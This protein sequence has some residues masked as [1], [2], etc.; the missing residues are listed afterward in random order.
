LSPSSPG[1]F[2]FFGP[3]GSGAAVLLVLDDV[4]VVVARR[5][6]EVE[7]LVVARA[8][9][10]ELR[11]AVLEV[12]GGR[13]L[14]VVGRRV[15]DVVGGSR[16]AAVVVVEGRSVGVRVEVVVV[17]CDA[18]GVGHAEGGGASRA[19]NFPGS[20]RRTSPPKSMPRLYAISTSCRASV[21]QL[22]PLAR[23]PG[24]D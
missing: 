8:V 21:A 7:L 16:S 19:A 23:P 3:I 2:G 20:S 11:G 22:R 10:D 13:L 5:V 1:F 9:V 17:V 14:E 4:L 6:E 12:V 15:V 18:G 24:G